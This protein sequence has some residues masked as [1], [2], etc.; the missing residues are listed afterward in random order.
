MNSDAENMD[1]SFP[2]FMVL[3]SSEEKPNTKLSPF[4]VEKFLLDNICPKSCEDNRK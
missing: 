3:E 2:N 1:I 4:V